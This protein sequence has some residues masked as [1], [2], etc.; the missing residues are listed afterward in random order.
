MNLGEY[1]VRSQRVIFVA[2]GFILLGGFA[3]YQRL[4]RLE[5]P[6]FTIKEDRKSVV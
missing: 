4:G 5:D 1:S 3:A 6:E 2:M